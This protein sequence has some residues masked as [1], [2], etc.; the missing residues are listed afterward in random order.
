MICMIFQLQ[1]IDV[2]KRYIW[3]LD[4]IIIGQAQREMFKYM[5]SIAF[6]VKYSRL[7]KLKILGSC[8]HFKLINSK[9]ELVGMDFIM[10]LPKTLFGYDSNFLVVDRLTKTI[11]FI[12]MVITTMAFGV[13]TLFMKNVCKIHET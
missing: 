9:I 1:C 13:V 5:L 2:F 10:S 7:N 6:S 11:H 3:L 8:N 12:P 4:A